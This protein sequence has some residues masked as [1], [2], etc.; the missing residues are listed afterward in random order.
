M[1]VKINWFCQLSSK[2]FDYFF[3][4]VYLKHVYQTDCIVYNITKHETENTK[5]KK[6]VVKKHC[7]KN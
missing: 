1:W 5:K 3:R 2:D 7:H 6:G 4:E